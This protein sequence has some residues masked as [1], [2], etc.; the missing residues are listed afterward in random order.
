M[1][2]DWISYEQAR[3]RNQAEL[4]LASTLAAK[5]ICPFYDAD[6]LTIFCIR[7]GILGIRLAQTRRIDGR[8]RGFPLNEYM[9]T[10]QLE[11]GLLLVVLV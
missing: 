4:H 9:Y 10:F 8:G 5:A 2:P 7:A 6:M 1:T 11:P 3:R